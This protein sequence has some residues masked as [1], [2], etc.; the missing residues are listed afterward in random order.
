MLSVNRVPLSERGKMG[1]MSFFFFKK[2]NINREIGV[3]GN[4][5]PAVVVAAVVICHCNVNQERFYLFG[6]SGRGG[7]NI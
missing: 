4:A 6:Y 3:T 2:K 7:K 5:R 1:G